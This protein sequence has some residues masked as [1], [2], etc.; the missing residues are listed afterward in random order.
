MSYYANIDWQGLLT[1]MTPPYIPKKF[2]N[3]NTGN[4]YRNLKGD[5]FLTEFY[6]TQNNKTLTLKKKALSAETSEIE[7]WDSDSL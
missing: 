3:I 2:R 6:R 7:I 1:T 5:T 4:Y